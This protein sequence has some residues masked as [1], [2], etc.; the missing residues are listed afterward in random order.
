MSSIHLLAS[1]GNR[2]EIADA[3]FDGA[4]CNDISLEGSTPLHLAMQRTDYEARFVIRALLNDGADPDIEDDLGYTARD[5]ANYFDWTFC[6]RPPSHIEQLS[7][8][9]RD[10]IYSYLDI[11]DIVNLSQTCKASS[12]ALKTHHL[13]EALDRELHQTTLFPTLN[14]REAYLAM[15]ENVARLDLE[16]SITY[17]MQFAHGTYTLQDIP[18]AK[19][20]LLST[21]HAHPHEGLRIANLHLDSASPLFDRAS[22]EE[23]LEIHRPICLD[24]STQYD[25][26]WRLAHLKAHRTNH[27]EALESF[28]VLVELLEHDIHPFDPSQYRLVKLNWALCKL[29]DPLNEDH[30]GVVTTLINIQNPGDESSINNFATFRLYTLYLAYDQFMAEGLTGM[31]NLANSGFS[32]ACMALLIGNYLLFNQYFHENVEIFAPLLMNGLENLDNPDLHPDHVKQMRKI[33][34]DMALHLGLIEGVPN[35]SPQQHKLILN[36]PMTY[37]FTDRALC[38]SCF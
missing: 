36:F 23:L 24:A 34:F 35:F 38:N 18:W 4:D 27:L 2:W 22:A 30:E 31:A 1:S 6:L 28:N 37:L 33:A 13:W 14:P 15:R 32:P 9:P 7:K 17:A 25:I 26:Q 10:T 20:I 12:N 3:L 19:Q 8:M 11:D 5:F 21:I 16:S 29:S